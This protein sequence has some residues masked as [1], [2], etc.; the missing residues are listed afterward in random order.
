MQKPSNH[1]SQAARHPH[2]LSLSLASQLRVDMPLNNGERS[3]SDGFIYGCE[4]NTN[5]TKRKKN[6]KGAS[7]PS[8]R[9]LYTSIDGLVL[10]FQHQKKTK[11]NQ[12]S[13]IQQEPAVPHPLHVLRKRAEP[14]TLQPSPAFFFCFHHSE[15]DRKTSACVE[16]PE[17]HQ[18]DARYFYVLNYIRI[19]CFSC[20]SG[21]LET[22][23]VQEWGDWNLSLFAIDKTICFSVFFFIPKLQPLCMALSLARDRKKDKA[24]EEK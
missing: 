8:Q 20:F 15:V 7:R 23:C 6:V 12:K 11:P 4:A 1:I 13:Y 3:K 2:S 5:K 22:L 10:L 19:W 17:S 24:K 21:S 9:P 16:K 18:P 14:G